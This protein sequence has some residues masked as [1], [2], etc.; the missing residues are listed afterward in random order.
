MV[1]F[2]GFQSYKV[3]NLNLSLIFLYRL[4]F[5]LGKNIGGSEPW[6]SHGDLLHPSRT[7]QEQ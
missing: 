7:M 6:V 4:L 3:P 1:S 5:V 2:I